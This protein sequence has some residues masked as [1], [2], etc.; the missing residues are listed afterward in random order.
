LDFLLNVV[1]IH[2][3]CG[4]EYSDS[5]QINCLN[6]NNWSYTTNALD[7]WTPDVLYIT[8]GMQRM[9]DM[10]LRISWLLLLTLTLLLGLTACENESEAYRRGFAKGV[11]EGAKEAKLKAFDDGYRQGY[12]I[13]FEEGRPGTSTNLSGATLAFY[14]ILVWAGALKILGSLVLAGLALFNN[15][16][17]AGE[18]VGKIIFSVL[19]AVVTIV[20]VMYFSISAT[21]VNALLEPAPSALF[22]QIL[23]MCGAAIGMFLFLE[24]LFQVCSA[25]SHRPKTEAWLMAVI[26]SLISLFIPI[27]QVF[28]ERVPE[29]TR[30][31]GANLFTGVLLGG[32][33]WLGNSAL[34]RRFVPQNP[35]S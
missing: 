34:N 6:I 22:V 24:V 8:L 16:D 28:W 4:V 2:T 5:Y 20:L 12:Q 23:W 21:V 9:L 35:E 7:Y 30:Y 11:T 15:S 14:K 17:T 25:D 32:L 3:T 31:I 29:V 10:K 33:Y 26:A 18:A 27:L 19:G 13:G 1:F